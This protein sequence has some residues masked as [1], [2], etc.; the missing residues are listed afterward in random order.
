[1]ISIMTT[2]S[3]TSMK[4]CPMGPLKNP[5]QTWLIMGVGQHHLTS[6]PL[7]LPQIPQY[8][9]QGLLELRQKTFRDLG[10]LAPYSVRLAIPHQD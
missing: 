4:T 9:L 2:I 3:L 1:M 8:L 6:D 7:N 10:L 5:I